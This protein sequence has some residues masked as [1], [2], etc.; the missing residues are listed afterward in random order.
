MSGWKHYK[1][2]WIL[3]SIVVIGA[4]LAG[5]LIT[6]YL[7]DTV[8]RSAVREYFGPINGF[9]GALMGLGMLFPILVLS[10]SSAR[11]R[12][13]E[14]AASLPPPDELR[15][16]YLA[17]LEHFQ[18][19]MAEKKDDPLPKGLADDSPMGQYLQ[20]VA[21]TTREMQPEQMA[22]FVLA[23]QYRRSRN[24]FDL[25]KVL[26]PLIL[27]ILVWVLSSLAM[28]F[29][30]WKLLL[31]ASTITVLLVLLMYCWI[32]WRAFRSTR[33]DFQRIGAAD[34]AVA[35]VMDDPHQFVRALEMMEQHDAFLE[36]S[37][38]RFANPFSYRRRREHLEQALQSQE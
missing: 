10:R 18:A 37:R 29:V 21:S 12:N 22:A 30:P 19:A 31:P 3:S 15:R 5:I 25:G 14:A 6:G 26:F 24:G 27:L 8:G 23:S 34:L 13:Q 16:L 38:R 20:R 17:K 35:Q 2:L 11:T 9:A 7:K 32:E 4:P 1:P 36:T 33:A 28:V